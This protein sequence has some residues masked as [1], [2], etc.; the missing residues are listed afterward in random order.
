M[1]QL[2][3]SPIDLNKNELQNPR[4]QNLASDPASP[5]AGQFYYHTGNA[6]MMVYN[7][8]TFVQT[9]GSGTQT[10][11][12]AKTFSTLVT[13]PQ[14]SATGQTGAA[15]ATK[16]AGGT[17]T[18]APASG[19]FVTG[20]WVVSAGGDI[21]VCTAGGTP[22]TWVRVGS[23]L[24]G[25]ANTWTS[26][27]VFNG[28]ITGN[29]TINLTGAGSSSVV[30]TFS[31]AQYTATGQTGAATT[32]KYAGG[33]ASGSP[34]SGA[35]T[36][37]DWIVTTGGDI[38]VCTASGTPGTW[39]RVGSYLLASANT[40]T[41]TNVFN[42]AVTGNSTINLTGTAAS[43]VAGTFTGTAVIASGLT[44][45]TS[46][47]RYVGATAS[48]SPA[49]GTFAIGDFIVDRTGSIW[50][51]TTAGTPGTWA[52]LSSSSISPS[53]TVVSETAYG[54]SSS[55]GA[56]ASYS[57]GDHTH[58][59]PALSAA[60]PSTQAIG[61]AAATGTGTNNSRDDHKHAMPAFG[62]V[63]AQTA[64]GASSN[65]GASAAIARTDHVHGTPTHDGSAHSAISLSSLSAPT[66]ALSM[67]TQRIIN[68]VDPTGPQDAATKNYVDTIA[69]GIDVHA[70]VRVAS[71]A[72]VSGTYTAAGG[73]S[74]RGQFTA[75]GTTLD[76]VTLVAG[77]RV[78]LKDQSTGAQ[79]GIWVVTTLGSGANGVWD[80]AT[81]FDTDAE[82]T[83][84]AFAFVEEGTTN[85]DSGWL[86]TTDNPITIGGAS[87][88]ALVF[89]QFSGAGQIVAGAGLTKTGNTLDVGQGTGITVSANDV[90]INTAV[91][92]QKFAASVGDGSTTSIVVTHSL[93][94]R[95]VTVEV[96]DNTT[97]YARI[98]C[99]VLH[100]STTTITL[101][102]STAPTSNQYR[103]VVHA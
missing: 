20:D 30:G 63:T 46:A 47:S 81:D 39:S 91:V 17:A 52:Q 96:Y 37:G 18:V 9:M 54:A 70:S 74:A 92:V 78:L 56:S 7:G 101:G 61:D 2:F 29:N 71:A 15:T 103:A 98:L 99:D 25:A 53:A 28:A 12:G 40:W 57:R 6:V 58:G 11:A 35:Y 83:A 72:N 88:T 77:N 27:N 69:Q 95:D 48:G 55:A 60:T 90:A 93:G 34:A 76:G 80:R 86:L 75:M 59:T 26:T 82:V 33:T 45:A 66:A 68:V 100:T 89:A 64:F 31:A 79:N 94:T 51:C 23:Y 43:S 73:T 19:T 87:G 5:V 102:F 97:P 13:S 1:A 41:S 49:S 36:L 32:T 22:G 65:N 8:A 21:F 85:A 84:G 44:G 10:F 38:Y 62:T 4:A 67:G 14:F 24:L 3:L 42:G 16:Y 50:I